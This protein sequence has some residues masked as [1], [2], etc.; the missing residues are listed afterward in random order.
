MSINRNLSFVR[1]LRALLV[2]TVLTTTVLSIAHVKS[3]SAACAA[4]PTTYGSVTQTIN[5]AAGT[6]TVWSR[7]SAPDANANSYTLEIDGTTSTAMCNVTVG[8]NSAMPTNTWTWVNYNS[9]NAKITVTLTAGTHTVRMVGREAGVSLDRVIFTA[10]ANC[11]PTPATGYG[12]NCASP[13]ATDASPPTVSLSTPTNGQVVSGIVPITAVANDDI[14]VTKVE[15]YVDNQLKANPTTPPY[16]INWS[17]AGLTGTHTLLAKAYDAAGNVTTSNSVAVTI[18]TTTSQTG[19]IT[20]AVAA[21]KCLDNATGALVDDNKAQIYVC[22]GTTSQQWTVSSDGTI[23]ANNSNFCLEV[24]DGAKVSGSAV[25]IHTCNGNASQ[26]W[27]VNS[28][29]RT[30][31]NPNSGLCLDIASGLTADG[32]K[33]QLYTCNGTPA[34]DWTFVIPTPTYRPEDVNQD[35]FINLGD[36]VI[37]SS[38]FNQ[39]GTTAALGRSDVNQD[40]KVN[41]A[42]FVLLSSKFN[43]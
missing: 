5:V 37:M 28:S 22:N 8:D 4:L 18:A 41:L 1:T 26:V 21:N 20:S 38:K 11:T 19:T 12:D 35:G 32:S 15:F 24:K 14:G 27:A 23:H 43:Q 3:A 40:G 6:Y 34:Q 30:I 13:P 36:F 16:T 42:D 25:G 2:A 7:I 29:A 31:T 10:D 39:V 33:V 9:S 17:T